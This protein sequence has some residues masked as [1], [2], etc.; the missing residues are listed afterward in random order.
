MSDR[1]ATVNA[2]SAKGWLLLATA[3]IAAAA[4]V[5]FGVRW[6]FG[7]MLSELTS[8]TDPS[9]KHVASLARQ[10]AGSDPL[11]A[12][13]SASVNRDFISPEKVDESVAAFKEVVLLSPNDYRWWIELGRAAEQ[14]GRLD[15]AQ[16]SFQRATELAPAY[17]YPRWQFGNFLLRQGSADEAFAQ[18]RKAAENNTTYR[19]QVFSLAWDYFDHDPERVEALAADT[20][21]AR[22]SLAY[23]YAARAQASD[24]LRIWNTLDADQKAQNSQI[25]KTI[26]QAFTEKKFFRQGLEFSRQVGI[27]ADAQ[28]EAITNPGFEKPVGNPEDNHYGWNVE[29][30]DNKLDI[31]TDS[32]TKHSGN[33]SLRINFRTFVKPQ[34]ANPWQTVALRPG[35]KYTLRFWMR[36]ENLRSAGMP[37]IEVVE[38]SEYRLLAASAAAAIGTNDWQEASVEFEVPENVDGVVVRLARA[39]C[40]DACP[41]VG[42]LW[43]DDFS[44]EGK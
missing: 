15:L 30:G 8:P 21:D 34:L 24:S 18:L 16:A 1:L 2:K 28:L 4:L 40:G 26:A 3:L 39:Y 41:L 36:T 10:L 23:F 5:W 12:W 32:S 11:A 13:L 27:D 44:L 33:R 35:G 31:N 7:N 22:V 19:E 17:A 9:S 29:R 38:A 6:Q 37:T 20:P 43:L 25:A 42:I 14:A